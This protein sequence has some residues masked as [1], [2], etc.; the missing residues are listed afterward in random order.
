MKKSLSVILSTAMA[1]SMFSSVAFG[2]TAD[3]FADLKDLDAAAKA[4]ID[5]MIQAGIFDGVS[6]TSFGLK[7]EMNRA[8]F[9]KVAA[10]IMGLAV[11]ESLTTSSF[12]DV[13]ADDAANGYALP[14]I[15]ALKKAGVT[16]GYGEG[17]YNPAG[18]VTKEQ[19]A[20]FLVRVLGKDAEA[21]AKPGVNDATVSDWAKGYVALALE[22]KL[23]SN[24]ADGTFGG[25][26]NAT[27]DLLA[28][29]AYE[30]KEQ[31]VAPPGTAVGISEV[32]ATGAYNLTVKLSGVVDTANA[33][34]AVK[35]DGTAV[36]AKEVK[37]SDDKRTAVVTLDT[38]I[39]EATYEVTVSGVDNLDADKATAEVDTEDEKISKINFVTA[40][41]TLPQADDIRVEFKVVNQY[42]E[43]AKIPASDL[44]IDVTGVED[45]DYSDVSG[46]S[47]IELD[48]SDEEE[49]DRNDRV[50][51]Q[52]SDDDN[53]ISASKVFTIGDEQYI[54]KVE[55]GK[56]M[57]K[58]GK[59]ISYVE[60]ND[61]DIYLQVF[62]YDQYGVRVLNEETL[63]DDVDLSGSSDIDVYN[64]EAERFSEDVD[65]DDFPDLRLEVEADADE[66]EQTI[67]IFASNSSESKKIKIATESKPASVK[68]DVSSV[69]LSTLD[70]NVTSAD[71]SSVLYN[72]YVPITVL[73]EAGEALTKDE[74]AKAAFDDELEVDS[75]G[76]VDDA[77]IVQSGAYKGQVY[78][79]GEDDTGSGTV[80]ITIDNKPEQKASLKV[81][82]G[83]AR[84]V[85]ELR[86]IKNNGDKGINING[87]QA[88]TK[89]K[90]AAFDQYGE[91]AIEDKYNKNKDDENVDYVVQ[92][93][94][95]GPGDATVKMHDGQTLKGNFDPATGALSNDIT[96]TST[97]TVNKVVYATFDQFTGKEIR[98]SAAAVGVYKLKAEL[99]KKEQGDNAYTE[100]DEITK[101]YEVLDTTGE[102]YVWSASLKGGVKDANGVYQVPNVTK[103]GATVVDG[104]DADATTVNEEA[105]NLKEIGKEVVISA[106]DGSDTLLVPD[107][108]TSVI[109]TGAGTVGYGA[110]K[111]GVAYVAAKDDK[112]T[113]VTVQFPTN[114]GLNTAS[115][116]IKGSNAPFN[117]SEFKGG[118]TVRTVTKA[119]LTAASGE[120]PIWNPTL[121]DE[122]IGVD[123][124]YGTEYSKDEFGNAALGVQYTVIDQEN[125]TDTLTISPAGVITFSQTDTNKNSGSFTIKLTAPSGAEKLMELG[126]QP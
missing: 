60:E 72:R 54:S 11:D 41:D 58:T 91:M 124:T 102:T 87:V 120:T 8:Q 34:I 96:G 66:G 51:V 97:W 90:F 23:L 27:R 57:D 98:L 29:G 49:Y 123:A 82:V 6:E 70:G 21:A 93:T 126:Y 36:T 2:K 52:I 13:T 105:T 101:T 107:I 40:S 14:Y 78:I 56:L 35:R 17:I 55:I 42:G 89:F 15:E 86:I 47:A 99:L 73:N 67:T 53:N 22:L 61:D 28:I 43:D 92:L 32:K 31:Y 69:T 46:Q 115:L 48:L 83:D 9:A 26:A 110:V 84:E 80:E 37:W 125:P 25:T 112:E 59:E 119:A 109:V 65:S 68:F 100:V 116:K 50:N 7:E 94:F 108:A 19:L 106:K 95:T 103:L 16:D 45:A 76:A 79:K 88:V 44:D 1:L 117:I 33:K 12:S 121:L 63:A 38:K 111:D 24:N 122:V 30:A 20:T 113:S 64:V 81:K 77:Y 62:A 10:L 114:K 18:K 39:I 104:P 75:S 118:K 4:K 85:E 5:A 3:D 71:S 74:I